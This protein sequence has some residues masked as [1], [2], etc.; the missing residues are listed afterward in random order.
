MARILGT[1]DADRLRGGAAADR[2]FGGEGRDVLR[3]G[4]GGDRLFG[5]DRTDPSGARAAIQSTAIETGMERLLFAATAPGDDRF[6]Y[7]VSQAGEIRRFDP[8]TGASGPFLTLP[9][10]TL[11]DGGEQGLLGLA[12]HPDYER[13]GRFFLHLVNADNDVE[14]VEFRRGAGALADPDSGRTIITI[15]HR[16]FTNHN[17][18]TVAFGPDGLLYISV[19]D[20]GGGGDPNET[21]QDPSDLLGNILRIDVDRDGFPNNAAKN[22]AIPADNPFANGGGAPEVWDFGLRNP[23]RFAFDPSNGDLLIGDVGQGQR[24]EVDIHRAGVPGGLNFGWDV[25]E[26]FLPFEG[27]ESFGPVTDPIFDYDRDTGRSITG[28]AFV[29]EGGGL[30]GAYAFA[31][32]VS[33]AFFTLRTQGAAAFGAEE[34]SVQIRGDIPTLVAAFATGPDGEF[35]AVSLTGALFRLRFGAGA[36]DGDDRIFGGAGRDTLVGGAGDDKLFGGTAGDVLR[37]GVGADRISGG[38]GDDRLIGG[39]GPDRFV[40]TLNAGDDVARDFRP[41]F[42]RIVLRAYDLDGFDDLAPALSEAGGDAVIDFAL[43][44]GAGTL[45]LVGVS[46]AELEA[47]SFFF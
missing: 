27:G 46:V 30:A 24:E 20:G 28:G 39:A 29:P 31:D 4:A 37:G 13:N 3:G 12:F 34:R 1:F 2:I 5:F 38:A 7:L 9:D 32:F 16:D 44:G 6:F 8:E 35:Y 19:G 43:L 36:G 45:R 47:E 41:G 15:P 10:G 14:I 40:F 25:R 18:G 21:G 26:G 42:D 22:Y 17:G 11:A 33:G 23:F